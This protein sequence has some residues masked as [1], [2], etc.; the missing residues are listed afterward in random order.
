MN[1]KAKKLKRY[2]WEPLRNGGFRYFERVPLPNISNKLKKIYAKTNNG[3][4]FLKLSRYR[5]YYS[6]LG[7][8]KHHLY[9][10]CENSKN[11]NCWK[12]CTLLF[13]IFL[14]SK[15]IPYSSANCIIEFV[16]FSKKNSQR[17]CGGRWVAIYAGWTITGTKRFAYNIKFKKEKFKKRQKYENKNRANWIETGR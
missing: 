4:Y 3:F 1:E 7:F 12:V 8:S 13:R 5:S 6:K 17:S 2:G 10:F 14:L 16:E 15:I 9:K 11:K